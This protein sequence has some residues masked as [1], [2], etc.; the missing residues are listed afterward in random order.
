[1]VLGC[2][3]EFNATDR[4]T[5]TRNLKWGFPCIWTCNY[6][7]DPRR[8]KKVRDYIERV[9]AVVVEVNKPLFG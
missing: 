6:N 5:Q 9:G 8:I 2:H 3:E 7:L 4:Y 1:M